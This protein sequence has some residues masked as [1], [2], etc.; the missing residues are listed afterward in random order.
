M[1]HDSHNLPPMFHI[2][3]TA[4]ASSADTP[5]GGNTGAATVALL[6]QLSILRRTISPRERVPQ[7]GD[8]PK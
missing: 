5:S 3:V 7:R 8:G 1:S 4:D 2:D 6:R